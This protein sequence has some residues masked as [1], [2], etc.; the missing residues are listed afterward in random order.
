MEVE[1]GEAKGTKKM[2]RKG[3]LR[4]KNL[5]SPIQKTSLN[6][7]KKGGKCSRPL[8][9]ATPVTCVAGMGHFVRWSKSPA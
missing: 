5:K 9:R 7:G 3:G 1:K 8:K 2:V 6:P 4:R